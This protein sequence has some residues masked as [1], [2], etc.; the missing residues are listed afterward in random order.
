MTIELNKTFKRL[1]NIVLN[2][3]HVNIEKKVRDSINLILKAEKKRTPELRLTQSTIVERA[4]ACLEC[5]RGKN[6]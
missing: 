3:V 2:M 1:F 5:G 6:G 4:I